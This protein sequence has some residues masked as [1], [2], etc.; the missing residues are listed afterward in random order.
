MFL[1]SLIEWKKEHNYPF[2][3]MTEA[4]INL[5]DDEELMQMMSAA[6]FCTVFLGIETPSV[7]GLEECSKYQNV[8]R[9]LV[10]TV[11]IIQRNGMQVMGGFI[12]GFDSD[13]EHI[14]DAQIKY[15]HHQKKMGQIDNDCPFQLFF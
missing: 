4:S 3:I 9:D 5:A 14:F 13:S 6:N 7:E 15:N 8:R 1:R 10:E 11:H 2:Q 12:V